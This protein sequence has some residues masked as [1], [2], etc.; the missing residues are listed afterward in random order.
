[1]WQ[2][3]DLKL[4]EE[5]YQRMMREGIS[6]TA[7]IPVKGDARYVKVVVYDYGADIVGSVV[8]KLQ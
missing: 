8:A 7:R 4:T 6:Y 2:N 3:I 1:L 5:S